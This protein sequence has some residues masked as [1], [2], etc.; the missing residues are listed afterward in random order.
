MDLLVLCPGYKWSASLPLSSP[1]LLPLLI[2]YALRP[3]TAEWIL[4]AIRLI[5]ATSGPGHLYRAQALGAAPTP[6]SPSV[7]RP[8]FAH[9]KYARP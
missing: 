3:A 2:S 7:A 4:P 1:L 5:A 6:D 9:E 8:H